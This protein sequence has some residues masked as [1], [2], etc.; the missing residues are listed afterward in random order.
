MFVS[1]VLTSALLAGTAFGCAAAEMRRLEPNSD[2]SPPPP[3]LPG[4]NAD[5]HIAVFGDT[6]YIYPTT[7]G[8]EGWLSTSFRAWSSRDLVNWKDEGVILDLPRDLVWAD[9]RAW[10]PAIATKLGKYYYYYSAAQNVGVAVADSPVGPFKDP[11]GKPLVAKTDFPRMQAIDPMVFVDDDGSAYL[12]WGQGRCKAVKLNDDMISFNMAD[13]RDLTPP[14]YNEGPFVHKR[15]G[16][17][18]LTWSEFDTRDPRYSVAYATGDSPLGP[19]TKAPDN[20]IL[21]QSGL[22]KGA[23]HHSLVQI[24]GDPDE[25]RHGHDDHRA[26]AVVRRSQSLDRGAGAL[27]TNRPNRAMRPGRRR[28]APRGREQP[29]SRANGRS[30]QAARRSASV[31]GPT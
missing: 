15:N 26:I 31:A 22:V 1:I 20:P 8:T 2:R 18:Y 27:G 12:Y 7:D 13:V 6:F 19:F 24:P 5:P 30:S 4:V 25:R 9:I 17:Y 21:R 29:P 23:G 28:H 16:Q 3:V 10:A 14:G 11:L